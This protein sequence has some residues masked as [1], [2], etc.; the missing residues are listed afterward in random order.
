VKTTVKDYPVNIWYSSNPGDNCYVAQVMEMPNVTAVGDTMEE[1][2]REIQVALELNLKVLEED[3]IAPPAPSNPIA[4]AFGRLGGQTISAKKRAA[5]R[6]N[7]RK[8][9]RP[10]KAAVSARQ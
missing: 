3:G 5:A 8:G 6:R 9:G 10:H 2:A 1:A 4:S 7:G